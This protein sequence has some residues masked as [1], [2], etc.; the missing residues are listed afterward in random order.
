MGKF[1]LDWP[2]RCHMGIMHYEI[3]NIK[4]LDGKVPSP[5]RTHKIMVTSWIKFL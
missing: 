5:L 3:R 4:L 1:G 2:A